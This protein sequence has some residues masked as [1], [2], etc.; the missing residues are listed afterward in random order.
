MTHDMKRASVR[1]IARRHAASARHAILRGNR[2]LGEVT[3][4]LSLPE[5]ADS[6]PADG[7][8]PVAQRTTLA[9]LP[10]EVSGTMIDRLLKC[11][12][13]VLLM[14]CDQWI[15][16]VPCRGKQRRSDVL[17]FLRVAGPRVRALVYSHQAEEG[18]VWIDVMSGEISAR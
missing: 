3:L 9:G 6:L 8:L 13:V 15:R 4:F 11:N 1:D 10:E 14:E 16:R 17:R 7:V 5:P 12:D 18:P 2:E